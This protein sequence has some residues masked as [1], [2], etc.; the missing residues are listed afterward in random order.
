MVNIILIGGQH[1]SKIENYLNKTSSIDVKYSFNTLKMGM[2]SIQKNYETIQKLVYIYT[3]TSQTFIDDMGCLMKLLYD[4]K[5]S[6]THKSIF[7]IEEVSLYYLDTPEIVDNLKYYEQVMKKTGYQTYTKHPSKTQ[8]E[9]KYLEQSILGVSEFTDKK[10]KRVRVYRVERGSDIKNIME[11]EKGGKHD[12]VDPFKINT[13][14]DYD[15]YKDNVLSSESGN[16]YYDKDSD[17]LINQPKI[18]DL[19]IP[20]IDTNDSFIK[21]N[22]YI[23]SGEP[24]SGVSTNTSLFIK[25]SLA[26]GRTLTLID[27]TN[28]NDTENNIRIMEIPFSSYTVR[29]LINN[30]NLSFDDNLRI[31]KCNYFKNDIRIDYLKYLLDYSNKLD[32]DLILIEC[33]SELLNQILDITGMNTNRVIYHTDAYKRTLDKITNKLNSLA[34]RVN[35]FIIP[36]YILSELSLVNNGA[37]HKETIN[38]IK[39]RF[40][41][42]IVVLDPVTE[43]DITGS[44]YNRILKFF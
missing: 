37:K 19:S 11:P 13:N 14:I 22:I 43:D 5:G 20:K 36:S 31:I 42:N 33:R 4:I 26:E 8:F 35:L 10:P 1:T 17:T 32:S 34:D 9:Y 3:D 6:K 18:E 21:R 38:E 29:D 30:C 39:E 23:F 16:M 41:K 40:R 2:K 28:S 25:S 24:K 44:L 7:D 12:C 15:E 27:L